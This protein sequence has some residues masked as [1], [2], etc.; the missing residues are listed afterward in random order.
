MAERSSDQ[1]RSLVRTTLGPAASVPDLSTAVFLTLRGFLV[2]Q[3][4]LES[5]S[6]DSLTP[7][8]DRVARQRR[9]L[10]QMLSAYVDQEAS[11]G[12]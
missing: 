8:S 6:Y 12:G 5:P 10:T 11:P 9:L 2:S 3:Q 7:E 1:I 4:L